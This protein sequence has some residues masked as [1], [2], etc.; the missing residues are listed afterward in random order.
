MPIRLFK[1]FVD[2]RICYYWSDYG[3]RQVSPAMATLQEAEEWWKHY[4]F[5]Q[6]P[7]RERRQSIY[8]RRSD[9]HK[10][11]HVDRL[12]STSGLVN[13]GRRVTDLP[14]RVDQDLAADKIRLLKR[15]AAEHPGSARSFH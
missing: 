13:Y 9:H 6:F 8:D 5:S 1:D 4:Q 7:G 11:E 12:I 15:V 3:E 10:R 2:G 14:I